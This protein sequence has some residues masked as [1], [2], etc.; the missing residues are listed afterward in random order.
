MK[1][2]TTNKETTN[3]STN[4][5]RRFDEMHKRVE[6][7]FSFSHWS[8]ITLRIG[9][10][11]FVSHIDRDLSASGMINGSS[12]NY[13][14]RLRGLPWNTTSNEIQTFLQG[15]LLLVFKTISTLLFSLH[16]QVVKLDKFICVQTKR[17]DRRSKLLLLSNRKKILI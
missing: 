14:V 16:V 8:N 7:I 2:R 3:F 17:I 12:S 5:W 13:C 15:F 9:S 1:M 4:H 10:F 6:E 11:V